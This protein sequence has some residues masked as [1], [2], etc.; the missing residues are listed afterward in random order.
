M[1]GR[2]DYAQNPDKTRGGEL[3]AAYMCA[4]ETAYL[5]F[6]LAKAQY[7]AITGREQKRGADVLCYQI[8]QS[9]NPGE[10]DADAA[11][12]IGYD[13]AMR[14][15]KGKHAF[16]VAS[17]TDHPHPHVHI[18]YN[19]TTLDCTHKFRDFI[20]SARAMRRLSDRICL[21]NNLSVILSPKL[22]SQGQFKHYG[23]WLGTDKPQTFQD[24]LKAAIDAALSVQ[25]NN[26]DAFLA[27]MTAAG[28]EHKWGRG[29]VLSFRTDGQE[30][31]TRLRASTLGEGYGLADIRAAIASRAAAPSVQATPAPRKV[32]LIIDIQKKLKQG[33]GPGFERWAKVYNLKQAAAALQYLQE[34]NLLVYEDLEVKADAAV[35]RFHDLS[36][37]LKQTETAMRRNSDLKA[38]IVDYARTRPIFAEYK[39]KKYSNKYLAEHK[40][41]IAAH[42]AAQA[43]MRELLQGERLPKM[44]VLKA[45]WQTLLAAKRSGYREY[46]A[47]QKD[48]RVIVAVKANID[49]LLGLAERGKNKEQER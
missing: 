14:W 27:F 15:T 43:A 29:G 13:L 12:K 3:I 11:L 25:P 24:R 16:F 49:H 38:A 17:H 35:E 30:R 48:M 23:E 22:K 31:F 26:F 39:A 32:N 34:N 21:E 37:K 41:D 10:V 36:D 2:F 1:K 33:K 45:E 8:R 18:Y 42:R 9:F 6:A 46:R 40:D 19:S 7:Y 44:A 4:P 20:G 5:E 47:A 28:Y